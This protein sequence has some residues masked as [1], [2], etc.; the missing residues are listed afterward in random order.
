M[1]IALC[2]LVVALGVLGGVVGA[3][4]ALNDPDNMLPANAGTPDGYTGACQQG[5]IGTGK[6]CQTD[7]GALT[8]YI[9][10]GAYN[11]LILEQQDIDVVQDVLRGM[12]EETDLSI[13]RHFDNAVVFSGSGQTDVIYQ[14]G[15]VPSGFDGYTWCDYPEPGSVFG[16]GQQFIRIEPNFYTRGLTCHETGH[17]VGLLHGPDASPPVGT[18]SSK[19]NCLKN[20]VPAD[21]FLG[22]NNK[23]NINATY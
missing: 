6:V 11:S 4:V 1:T 16:C 18:E 5:A 22:S 23:D 13:D 19:L 21:A 9:E 17:A 3:A 20:P 2:G 8:F 10:Q 15:A 7:N 12:Y 14:E